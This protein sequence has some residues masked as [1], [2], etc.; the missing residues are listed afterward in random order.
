MVSLETTCWSNTTELLNAFLM[1][2]SCNET[3]Q[4]M[5]GSQH[6]LNLLISQLCYISL[7]SIISYHGLSRELKQIRTFLDIA[8]QLSDLNG[9]TIYPSLQGVRSI[10]QSVRFPRQLAEQ[11]LGVPRQARELPDSVGQGAIGGCL[12]FR[13]QRKVVRDGA[14]CHVHGL[15]QSLRKRHLRLAGCLFLLAS[16]RGNS[17]TALSRPETIQDPHQSSITVS[18]PNYNFDKNYIYRL[19]AATL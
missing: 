3:V 16:L 17:L 7:I 8:V 11:I 6:Y 12:E 2:I 19:E 10:A 5:K 1:C 9:Q 18:E 13:W 4:K 15:H 14:A